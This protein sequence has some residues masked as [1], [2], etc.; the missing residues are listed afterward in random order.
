MTSIVAAG[1]ARP[2]GR[3]A[4]DPDSQL[5]HPSVAV[6]PIALS[7]HLIAAASSQIG[8]SSTLRRS[9]PPSQLI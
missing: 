1:I 8:H 7:D 6:S 4:K 2:Y 3:L 9:R 5:S